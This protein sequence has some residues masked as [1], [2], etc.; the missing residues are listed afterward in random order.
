MQSVDFKA[1]KDRGWIFKARRK[2][3]QMKND[4]TGLSTEN[5]WK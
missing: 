3:V 4:C 1:K 5:Y 2:K